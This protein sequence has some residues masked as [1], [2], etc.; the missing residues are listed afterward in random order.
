MFSLLE[1][2]ITLS[3][4]R[5]LLK[6][7]NALQQLIHYFRP[8][9]VPLLYFYIVKVDSTLWPGR[10][11]P[12][13]AN[14]HQ[15]NAAWPFDV[16]SLPLHSETLPHTSRIRI[17]GVPVCGYSPHLYMQSIVHRC[18]NMNGLSIFDVE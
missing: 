17:Y 9:N 1:S 15:F 14:L 12:L 13:C 10:S 16:P 5:M 18:D 7:Q 2:A 6:C 4:M 3:S 8:I 11:L